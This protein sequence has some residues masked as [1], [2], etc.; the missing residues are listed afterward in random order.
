VLTPHE[1]V[2]DAW[3]KGSIVLD[4]PIILALISSLC[5]G[6]ALVLTQFG[7]QRLAPSQGAAVSVP[8]A[9]ALL[10]LISPWLIDWHGFEPRAAGVFALVGLLFP[11]TVTLLTFEANRH[12]GPN[13]A[14]ALGNLTPL[15]ALLS[16][17]ILLGELPGL[18]QGVGIAAILVGVAA[19]SRPRRDAGAAWPWWAVLLPLAAAAIRGV[20]QP[21][22]KL[23]LG[24][25]PSPLAAVLIG[26]TVSSLVIAAAAL[27]RS[28]GRP[29][30]SGGAG[31]LWFGAVGLCNA[32]AVL[33]LYAAL[34]RGPVTVV[35][36]L[37]A[38]YPLL[39]LALSA[40]L[41]RATRL[42]RRLV[43]GVSLT[44]VGVAVLI[45]AR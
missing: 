14:G 1:A 37:V 39:T 18:W 40:L 25:W 19:L 36:P 42:E 44:V 3:P 12:M 15:F 4:S 31:V 9:T 5:F 7:L 10:W 45:A 33:A 29:A 35:S 23:G 11:A 41:L 20:V 6:L 24:V 27:P 30:R 13:V 22:T 8:T 32:A 26:Y 2:A 43:L 28:G 17:A 34:T 38:T 16:A 21:V